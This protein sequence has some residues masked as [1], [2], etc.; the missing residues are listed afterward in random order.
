MRKTD[1][2]VKGKIIYS[3]RAENVHLAKDDRWGGCAL[4]S[5]DLPPSLRPYVF[6]TTKSKGIRAH[7]RGLHCY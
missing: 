1:F 6:F 7:D 5:T 2:A 4:S 3:K